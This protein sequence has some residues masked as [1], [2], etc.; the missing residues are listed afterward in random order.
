[1][2]GSGLPETR[3]TCAYCGVGCGVL[4]RPDGR[5]GLE[6]RGDPDH[7]A[8]LGR[9]C[10]K[11]SALGETVGTAHRLSAPRLDGRDTDWDSALSHVAERFR[12]TIDQYGPESVGFYVS[13]QLLTEDYYVANKL[14]KGFIGTAN[15]DTNSRLCM[16]SSVAGHKRAFGTD[17]V[18]GTYEDL[19][20][21]DLVVLTGS[22]LAWCHPVL[23]QRVLAAKQARPRMRVVVIDPRRTAS[24]DIADMH[25]PVRP[26][27]DVALFNGLLCAL[28]ERGALDAAF[29]A[30]VE[31]F[32]DALAAA[33]GDDPAET[34]LSEAQL[35]A[36]YA[37]W[38]GTEKVVTVYSQ[39]VN[40]SSAGS[41][42]VN[43][44]LNCHLASGRIGRP[45]CGPFSVT[46]QPNAMGGRE[47][48]GLANTLACHLDIEN[49]DHRAAVRAFWGAPAISDRPG[50]KA[51]DMFRAVETGQIRALWIIHTNPAVSMPDANR[52]R[53]AI[54]GCD[55]VVVSDITDA[56]D[57]ARLADVLLPAAAWGEKEGTVTNS[58]RTISRQRAALAPWGQ[59]RPD[60]AI[61]AEVGRRM[62]WQQAFDYA[63]PAE[64]FREYAAL[65][66]VAGGFG[67]DFDIS[68]HADI[69]DSAYADLAPFRWPATGARQ[70][71]R[72]FGDGR[73]FTESGRGRMLPVHWRA[74][75]AATGR[76][77]PFRFNTG[78]IRDQ[79]HTMTRTGLS[80]RLSAHLAEPF[81][82]IHPEDAAAQGI[83]PA[84]LVEVS[85][86]QGRAILRAWV[87]D[88]VRRGDVFAP[89]HWTGETAPSARVDA[90]VAPVTDPVSGQ[91]ES[92]A[93]AVALAP[94][95]A[96]WYGFAVSAGDM[97]PDCA[98]WALAPTTTGYR[99]EL[100]GTNTPADWLA[101]ARR[102]FGLDETAEAQVASDPAKGGFRVAFHRDGRLE[103]ALFVAPTP[104]A[105][106]RSHLALLPGKEAWHALSGRSPADQPDP[107]P[108]VCSCFNVGVNTILTAIE[109]RGLMSVEE[110]GAALEAG[111]NCGSCRPE[112]AALLAKAKPR[113]AAEQ[114]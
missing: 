66:G 97:H 68:A 70:G 92:K 2:D 63:G 73:F 91:P 71:G 78:R 98:Y 93:A 72:F 59:S 113:E 52:V 17:T 27:S 30:H 39:G 49:A 112:I 54:A 42:K 10:S 106:M 53:D 36:F 22:N 41:D 104:V 4:L 61:L 15:I 12:E 29:L 114:A 60:W 18:P 23:Y 1:M 20:E 101:E 79:W 48:G 28:Y 69:A 81:L 19:E 64:I 87:T 46:G 100:A 35:E 65:S 96:R 102:L 105:V 31:G 56:T 50:L 25:L 14:M 16:A 109:T 94:F 43:A 80:P 107:G 34:G 21:A 75:V 82:E 85:S 110:I 74:P 32:D 55:F 7:P 5:G 51:V 33:S 26:G 111:T 6:V 57:T 108:M 83:A 88:T 77:F 8:N 84:S 24:C 90:L 76:D 62:G 45:G 95:A 67:R 13:G 3:S 40:Q 38:A 47:V 99:A 86:P 9:L 37:L 103:A 58:D 11:G 89:M 44:I